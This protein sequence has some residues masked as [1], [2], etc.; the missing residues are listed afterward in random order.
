M[1]E[2]LNEALIAAVDLVNEGEREA[3]ANG[4]RPPDAALRD[5][6]TKLVA[7]RLSDDL[8]YMAP[9]PLTAADRDILERAGCGGI[10]LERYADQRDQDVD[11]PA[12]A[13]LGVVECLRGCGWPTDQIADMLGARGLN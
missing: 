13:D 4:A 5:R 7:A 1:N 3:V 8:P 10:A 12:A 6:L 11:E 2:A 9:A